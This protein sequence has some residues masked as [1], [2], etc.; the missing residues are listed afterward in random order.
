MKYN[1]ICSQFGYNG[2]KAVLFKHLYVLN[3]YS[4]EN[5]LIN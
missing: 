3:Y 4:F 5:S 2:L 1:Y